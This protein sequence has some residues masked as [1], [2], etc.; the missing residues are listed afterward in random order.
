[1]KLAI[2]GL[3]K[4]GAGGA[5]AARRSAG[6]RQFDPAGRSPSR[7][8]GARLRS[9]AATETAPGTRDAISATTSIG[10]P[11]SKS[12][13]AAIAMNTPL[14]TAYLIAASTAGAASGGPVRPMLM[15]MIFAPLSAAYRM[16]RATVSSV[17]SFGEPK[18]SSQTPSMTLTGI[19]LTLKATPAVPT[20]SFVSWPMVPLTCVPWPSKSNGS[21]SSQM[22]SRGATKRPAPAAPT[23]CGAAEYGIVTAAQRRIE[24]PELVPER[25][26]VRGERGVL[27]GHARVE[28]RDG[29]RRPGLRL[30]VPRPFE[31]DHR[32]VPLDRRV[33]R[34]VGHEHRVHPVGRLR[35]LDVGPLAER[36][37]HRFGIFARIDP[38]DVEVRV[39]RP[40][41]ITALR[42]T[43]A[44][45]DSRAPLGTPS[46][47]FTITR[48]GV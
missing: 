26:D 30:D 31:V 43:P 48:P 2:E 25:R 40:R 12:L 9:T 36:A 28:H 44:I 15:L 1:M 37:R 20:L 8:R 7:R 10:L 29:D 45:A 34:I 3:L 46:R 14:P 23:S 35:V 17:P 21:S 11:S 42:E 41:A 4:D 24:P 18:R 22:K 27:I 32:Q 16:P 33:Q 19:S 39:R 13:P 38:H 47:N 5:E 6:R